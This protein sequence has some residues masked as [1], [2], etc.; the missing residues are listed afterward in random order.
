MTLRSSFA[1]REDGILL[2]LGDNEFGGLGMGDMVDTN[3]PKQVLWA[4]GE[5]GARL[6]WDGG[7]EPGGQGLDDSWEAHP[8]LVALRAKAGVASRGRQVSSR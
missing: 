5:S 4:V 6:K 3:V 1:V 2:A 8:M 7:N